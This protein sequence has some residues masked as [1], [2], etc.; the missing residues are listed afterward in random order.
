MLRIKIVNI[1][2]KKIDPRVAQSLGFEKPLLHGLCT[3]GI[4][5]HSVVKNLA[6]NDP[7]SLKSFSARFAAPIYP[8]DTLEIYMWAKSTAACV[9]SLQIRDMIEQVYCILI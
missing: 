8:G 4:A 7:N 6:N 2:L 9:L 1:N 3:Y 5:A